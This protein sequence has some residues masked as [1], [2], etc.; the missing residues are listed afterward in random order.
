MIDSKVSVI[1]PVYNTE[2]LISRCIDSI[3]SQTY[4]NFELLLVDDG[5]TDGSGAIIDEYAAGDERVFAFHKE[6]GGQGSARNLA[7]ERARGDFLAFVDSD[8]YIECDMLEKMIS[9]IFEKDADICICGLATLTAGKLILSDTYPAP[10]VYESPRE[11]LLDYIT[12]LNVFTG[13]C[14]KL[15]KKELFDNIR[16]PTIRANEDAYILHEILGRANRAVHIGGAYYVQYVRRG[17]T[18]QARYTP[19]RMALIDSAGRLVDYI[20]ENFPELY[21]H[22]AYKRVN[23]T[24]VLLRK[25]IIDF[26]YFKNRSDFRRLRKAL[27]EEYDRIRTE[28]PKIAGASRCTRI[29]RSGA[30]VFFVYSHL[31]GFAKRCQRALLAIASI[32][33]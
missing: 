13:M 10:H 31:Y 19:S 7:L 6:N 33:R 27:I 29:A 9:A 24:A 21:Q 5:S 2:K 16:F 1:V 8:D 25:I 14:N 12:T 3:L 20:S 28:H 32:F 15:Y 22:V 4:K 17:S 30:F 18:E 26:V 11:L 23:D